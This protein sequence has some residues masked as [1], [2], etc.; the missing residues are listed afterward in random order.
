MPLARPCRAQETRLSPTAPQ[1]QTKTTRTPLIQFPIPRGTGGSGAQHF[2]YTKTPEFPEI[3]NV[4]AG[5]PVRRSRPEHIRPA[6]AAFR[7]AP[8]VPP[9]KREKNSGTQTLGRPAWRFCPPTPA[10]PVR[11]D[12][13]VIVLR[14]SGRCGPPGPPSSPLF[15]RSH[16]EHGATGSRVLAGRPC[17]QRSQPL[18]VP[19]LREAPPRRLPR[20]CPR[21]R[22]VFRSCLGTRAGLGARAGG[23]HHAAEVVRHGPQVDRTAG[24]PL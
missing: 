15:L 21:L 4:Q 20:Q 1:G 16:Q 12:W 14:V 5:R 2:R 3:P 13:G 10:P 6:L 22:F 18:R 23:D 19:R 17:P 7:G 24:L 8:L 9:K 11:R